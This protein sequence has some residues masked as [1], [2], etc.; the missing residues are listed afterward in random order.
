MSESY[1]MEMVHSERMNVSVD[2][3]ER[4]DLLLLLFLSQQLRLFFGPEFKPPTK[5]PS[6]IGLFPAGTGA[7]RTRTPVAFVAQFKLSTLFKGRGLGDF[8][9]PS[10]RS[11]GR[12]DLQWGPQGRR[13]STWTAAIKVGWFLIGPLEKDSGAPLQLPRTEG[14]LDGGGK[15]E[16]GGGW[17]GTKR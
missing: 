6:S 13:S 5:Y 10:T 15:S 17:N 7:F 2:G 8:F 14:A 9:R 4:V 16:E 1:S 11:K 3:F 12:G